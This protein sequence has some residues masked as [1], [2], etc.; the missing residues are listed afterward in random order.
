[1]ERIIH[2]QTEKM[3]TEP[4]HNTMGIIK[5]VKK[6][7]S[8]SVCMLAVIFVFVLSIAEGAIWERI[9]EYD[10][11]I[12]YIN[13]ESI[14]HISETVV[15]AEFKLVYKEPAWFNAK[16]IDYYLI[17]QENNCSEKRYKVYRLTVYFRD[18]TNNNFMT[19]EEHDVKSDTFQSAIYEFICKKTK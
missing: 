9:S 11:T 16:S 17:E 4:C 8:L 10:D 15:R 3:N 18:G 19:K 2:E 6:A 12:I 1:M 14:R 5:R 13:N 7:W